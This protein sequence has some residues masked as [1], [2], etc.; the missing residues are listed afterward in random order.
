MDKP[1]DVQG[2]ADFLGVSV[3]WVRKAAARGEIPF[4]KV[5]RQLRFTAEHQR[6]IL[7]AHD[8]PV[9]ATAPAGVVQIRT[10]ARRTA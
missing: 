2:L 5:A 7:A 3:S 10:R 9:L 1:L 6:Q 8:Q 4:T